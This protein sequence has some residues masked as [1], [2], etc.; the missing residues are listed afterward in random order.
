MLLPRTPTPHM[1]AVPVTSAAMRVPVTAL[2]LVLAVAGCSHGQDPGDADGPAVRAE[3]APRSGLVE[4]IQGEPDP[5]VPFVAGNLV[6]GLG[7]EGAPIE[8]AASGSSVLMGTLAPAVVPDAEARRLVYNSWRDNRPVLRLHDVETGEDAELD[9]GALSAAWRGDGALAYFKADVAELGD[10]REYLGHAVV[11]GPA[12]EAAEWTTEPGRYVVVA[13]ARQ[14]LL[15]YRVRDGGPD[16]LVLDGPGRI[17]VLARDTS[18]LALSPDGSRALV[19]RRGVSPAVVRLVELGDGSEV[20]RLQLPEE[21]EW[22]LQSGSWADGRAVASASPGLV[23]L[24]L[25]GTGIELEQILR[26]PTDVV[27]GTLHE[28][29]L[30]AEGRITAWGEVHSR[31]GEVVDSAVIAVCDALAFRCVHGSRM[32]VAGGPRLVH[33]PSRPLPG[34]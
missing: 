12:G 9:E 21:V 1:P 25:E 15:V 32:P 26:L 33:N 8:L 4:L 10:P 2:V 17:R 20:A 3:T 7:E 34:H 6:H 16:L 5:V 18:L 29:Q 30:D 27:R 19:F 14:R 31:P 24:R 13:W 23:L 11:R 22:L 28:P